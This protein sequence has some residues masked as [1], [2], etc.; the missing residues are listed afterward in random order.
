MG[1]GSRNS[2]LILMSACIDR[3]GQVS[4]PSIS[5]HSPR[6]DPS[7]LSAVEWVLE[8]LGRPAGAR[9][10]TLAFF[11]K[12]RTREEVLSFVENPEF[13]C[14]HFRWFGRPCAGGAFPWSD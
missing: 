14:C 4:D 2:H 8:R 9:N 6:S 1:S 12:C 3:C 13:S 7:R 5:A 11:V 10:G